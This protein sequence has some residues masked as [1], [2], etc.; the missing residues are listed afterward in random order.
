[1]R[2]TGE[3]ALQRVRLRRVFAL[4]F[5]GGLGTLL[6]ISFF[7]VLGLILFFYLLAPRSGPD[8]PGQPPPITGYDDDLED[9]DGVYTGQY[10]TTGYDTGRHGVSHIVP[11][12]MHELRFDNDRDPSPAHVWL[13]PDVETAL[14]YRIAPKASSPG[15]TS[16]VRRAVQNELEKCLD[17]RC[18]LEVRFICSVCGD[19]KDHP[20]QGDIMRRG[21][22][23]FNAESKSFLTPAFKFT[24]RAN[25]I[26]QEFVP[27]GRLPGVTVQLLNNGV[28]FSQ[29]HVCVDVDKPGGCLADQPDDLSTDDNDDHAFLDRAIRSASSSPIGAAFAATPASNTLTRD[30]SVVD[31]TPSALPDI[32]ISLR[33]ENGDSAVS[34][35]IKIIDQTLAP[36]IADKLMVRENIALANKVRNL[37]TLP[38]YPTGYSG[39]SGLSQDAYFVYLHLSCA[40]TANRRF[41]EDI[42]GVT[43]DCKSEGPLRALLT[44]LDN[45][46]AKDNVCEKDPVSNRNV[47]SQN[48]MR[49]P[50][51]AENSEKALA[52]SGEVLLYEKMFNMR[53][54]RDLMS[55]IL[56]VG[57]ERANSAV[58]PPI[59]IGFESGTVHVPFQ[60][61][62]K[63]GSGANAFFGLVFDIAADKQLGPPSEK[64][65]AGWRKP[66]NDGSS[67]RPIFGLWT[68]GQSVA[69]PGDCGKF[70]PGTVEQFSCNHYTTVA[71]VLED[72]FAS[73]PSA[74]AVAAEAFLAKL[75]SEA[76]HTR[77]IWFYGHGQT[78]FDWPGASPTGRLLDHFGVDRAGEP[79]IIFNEGDQL[80]S[81]AIYN[82]ILYGRLL[83]KQGP[84]VVLVAC[85]I[86]RD[87]EAAGGTSGV[88]MPQAL[89]AIGARGVVATEAEIP[90]NTAAMFGEKFLRQL[91][92]FG[93]KDGA[94]L[95]MLRARQ[96]IFQHE[97]GNLFPLF[98]YYSGNHGPH[99]AGAF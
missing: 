62:H 7:V 28:S 22:L 57:L 82:S 24:P 78:R 6:A 20:Q 10:P 49:A 54:S 86:G 45:A 61:L 93:K 84:L 9:D 63:P 3:G 33:G 8:A 14:A 36:R 65:G 42:D 40:F 17:A 39:L 83:M 73:K 60:L 55:A 31:Q 1:M 32:D 69:A 50:I 44:Q 52:D 2:S 19:P 74:P 94:S 26:V 88:Y 89:S 80:P 64:V 21:P 23:A 71:R 68:K 38:P 29:V 85:E 16:A 98:F 79:K 43:K 99:G 30:V 87:V 11:D 90:A 75:K 92:R 59:R 4:G 70:L 34:L 12:L 97:G 56:D 27:F 41:R 77:L 67:L 51:A 72:D 13:T 48:W 46:C 81:A 37:A 66:L 91:A 47:A 95:A 5:V 53:D 35:N 96:E 25:A 15:A 18:N 76:L 58:T